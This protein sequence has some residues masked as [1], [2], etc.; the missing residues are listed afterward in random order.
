MGAVL[1]DDDSGSIGRVVHVQ[2]ARYGCHRG[3]RLRISGSSAK[4]WKLEGGKT[5][6]K[7]HEGTGWMWVPA[8]VDELPRDSEDAQL[9]VSSELE[10]Q[11]MISI[12]Q[13]R[14]PA[15][16]PA[17]GSSRVTV[18]CVDGYIG[19]VIDGMLDEDYLAILDEKR[20]SLPLDTSKK[21]TAAARRFYHDEQG[22]LR[23]QLEAALQDSLPRSA[24]KAEVLPWMRF[25]EYHEP[26]GALPPHTDALVRC[27]E[28]GRWSTHTLLV[29]SADCAEGGETIMLPWRGESSESSEAGDDRSA[30]FAVP[31]LRGRIFCFPH[32]CLHE[33]APTVECPKVLLRAEVILPNCLGRQ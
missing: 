27:K 11:N 3:D 32:G 25:L 1:R 29:H 26:E 17:P 21:K 2:R 23:A 4:L 19:Y 24:G 8:P 7:D 22:Q 30:G 5:I 33:G 16:R 9:R 31:P 14:C 10:L 28:T 12:A 18:A 6:P 20:L 13:T 15:E